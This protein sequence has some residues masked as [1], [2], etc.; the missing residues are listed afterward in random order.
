MLTLCIGAIASVEMTLKDQV[1]ITHQSPGEVLN[2]RLMS[3]V[4]DHKRSPSLRSVLSLMSH[5]SSVAID[6]DLH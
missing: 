5:Q 2:N 6:I 4:E 1:G 3:V